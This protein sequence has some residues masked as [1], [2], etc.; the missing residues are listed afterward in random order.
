VTPIE[1]RL[2]K[3][4]QVEG[5]GEEIYLHVA[6]FSASYA[7]EIIKR[8]NDLGFR[9]KKVEGC[10]GA[11]LEKNLG[12]RA[13]M[14]ARALG[15]KYPFLITLCPLAAQKFKENGIVAKTLIEFLAEKQGSCSRVKE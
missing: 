2:L 14:M 11:I 5:N 13:D 6:C 10:S 9:V 8:L 7:N 15:S 1:I 4:I 12:K 3:S